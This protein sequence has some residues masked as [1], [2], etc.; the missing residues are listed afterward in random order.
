M[1]H[2]P[3]K[4]AGKNAFAE[5]CKGAGGFEAAALFCRVG[6]SVLGEQASPDSDRFP[7]ID[8]VADLEKLSRARPGW[9][10][11]TRWLCGE[12]GGVFVQL[13]SLSSAMP[14]AVHA[15]LAVSLKEHGEAAAAVI[16]GFADGVM[17]RDELERAIIE[18]REGIEAGVQLKAVLEQ[19]LEDAR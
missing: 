17:K 19:M 1:N 8:V 12:M 7:A 4:L 13:P 14:A 6:K 3:E 5:T 2:T 18:V 15:A 9:P 11:V 10:H 16:N